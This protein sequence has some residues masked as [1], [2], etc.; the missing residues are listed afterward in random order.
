M[1]SCEPI[2]AFGENKMNNNFGLNIET[3]TAVDFTPIVKYDARSGR[4]FRV[5]RLNTGNGFESDQVD[6]TQIF[7]AIFDFENVEIGWMLFTPGAA[8]NFVLVPIGNQLPDRPSPKHKQGIRLLLHLNKACGGDK[9][10]REI[11]GNA[12]AF[13]GGM[14]EIYGEYKT[15]KAK[16][17]G[18]LPVIVLVTT[19]PVTTGSGDKKSTN[20]QPKFKIDGWAPRPPDLIH[21][22]AADTPSAAT[23]PS[24]GSSPVPPPASA[25]T[26]DD[27]D[28][29]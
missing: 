3:A 20:Y 26:S 8:P 7:K 6:I 19:L 16:Y 11:A 27:N 17:P 9:P 2:A 13:L 14:D 29:G 22:R 1:A 10:V 4:I 21:I 5:D 18:Q 24:T 25:A 28:F 12:K 15:E 23:R